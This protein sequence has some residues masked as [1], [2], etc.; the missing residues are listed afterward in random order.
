MVVTYFHIRIVSK[1]SHNRRHLSFL[2]RP[3]RG[4]D[5]FIHRISYIEIS[6]YKYFDLAG[7]S[8]LGFV[9]EY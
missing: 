1:T 6:R 9:F 7:E 2:L 8:A 3:W 4:C 5:T